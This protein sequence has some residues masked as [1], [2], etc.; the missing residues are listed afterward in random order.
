MEIYKCFLKRRNLFL[1]QY[2]ITLK[3]MVDK[4]RTNTLFYPSMLPVD[5]FSLYQTDD[6]RLDVRQ[7][8]QTEVRSPAFK[9]F[10]VPALLESLKFEVVAFFLWTSLFLSKIARLGYLWFIRSVVSRGGRFG[11]YTV[12]DTLEV[13]TW[14]SLDPVASLHAHFPI[15]ALCLKA[16]P[17][18][19]DH[20]SQLAPQP[21]ELK[22]LG[23]P[24][25]LP[26]QPITDLGM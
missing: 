23:V 7:E 5:L 3:I 4:S 22:C 12:E 9:S 18:L 21:R 2:L 16:L 25:S 10:Q 26:P 15:S 20:Q 13:S 1:Q 24:A 11:I 14:T 6:R 19:P 17:A 8:S